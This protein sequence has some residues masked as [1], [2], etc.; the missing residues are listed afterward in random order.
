MKR[1]LYFTIVGLLSL[2]ASGA[3]AMDS[4]W[5]GATF[6]CVAAGCLLFMAIV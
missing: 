3:M 2:L 1:G 5:L 4:N 6:G